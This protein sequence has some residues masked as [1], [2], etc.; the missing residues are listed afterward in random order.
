MGVIAPGS[1][2]AREDGTPR[3]VLALAGVTGVVLAHVVAY[4]LAYPDGAQRAAALHATGHGYWPL[5]VAMAALSMLAALA[6]TAARGVR[7]CA[8]VDG[9][10][11]RRLTR[12]VAW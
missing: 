1:T 2:P 7:G 3:L 5:A 8:A 9:S 10:W 12:L 6:L 11:G 4:G